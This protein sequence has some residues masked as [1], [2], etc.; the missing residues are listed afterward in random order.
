MT[1]GGEGLDKSLKKLLEV[2]VNTMD[3][4]RNNDEEDEAM[5]EEEIDSGDEKQAKIR[6]HLSVCYDKVFESALAILPTSGF[7]K[8][9]KQLL[10]NN[11]PANIQRKAL[12][13]L[14]ARFGQKELANPNIPAILQCLARLAM[15]ENKEGSNMLNKGIVFDK[16]SRLYIKCIP[17]KKFQRRVLKIR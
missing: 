14:N 5:E 11:Q 10:G 15:T 7:I 17:V 12:E 3:S 4:L 9:V 8:V 6:R 13:V 2:I 16:S 1:N